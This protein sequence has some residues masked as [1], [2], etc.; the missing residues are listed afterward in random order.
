MHRDPRPATLESARPD[1][2]VLM[3]FG[4]AV[5]F[6]REAVA[7][8]DAGDEDLALARVAR[9]RAILQEL[10]RNLDRRAGTIGRHLGAIYD[11]LLR[12]LSVT[13]VG[14][15]AMFEVVSDIETLA[16]TWSVLV[17]RRDAELAA[18]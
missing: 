12:R 9:V 5:R 17:E 7:A 3:L 15:T 10:D 18:A 16:Q 11:Y 6:G 8:F 1:E 14:R 4:G 2:L 13:E